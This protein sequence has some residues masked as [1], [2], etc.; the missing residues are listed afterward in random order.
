M[1]FSLFEFS[2]AEYFNCLFGN[3]S[4]WL[5][6]F[7]NTAAL[8]FRGYFATAGERISSLSSGTTMTGILTG[9]GN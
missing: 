3:S 2:L 1:N 8:S 9:K 5:S 6:C 7:P 4:L